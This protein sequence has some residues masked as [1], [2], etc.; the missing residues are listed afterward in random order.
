ME[1]LNYIVFNCMKTVIYSIRPFSLYIKSLVSIFLRF[2]IPG[3]SVTFF[4]QPNL[5]SI[6]VTY[7]FDG[8]Y[9]NYQ[10]TGA[11]V[12]GVNIYC[13]NIAKTAKN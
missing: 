6:I 7:R 1:Y 12:E 11:P 4:K 3:S 13:N 2:I 5:K 9:L 10:P 8:T